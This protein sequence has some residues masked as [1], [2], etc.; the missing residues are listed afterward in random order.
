MSLERKSYCYSRGKNKNQIE[1]VNC[2]EIEESLSKQ[3]VLA[4]HFLTSVAE[5][6]MAVLH[7]QH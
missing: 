1:Q 6:D 5:A 4:H 2:P 3:I 7:M